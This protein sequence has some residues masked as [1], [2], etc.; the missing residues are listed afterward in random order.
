MNVAIN[1]SN[2][3]TDFMHIRTEF[4]GLTSTATPTNARGRMLKGN[5]CNMCD[6]ICGARL[7]HT[8][9]TIIGNPTGSF[10]FAVCGAGSVE[11][12][13]VR[14]LAISDDAVCS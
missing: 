7:T 5:R 10:V 1:F 6:A 2:F 12:S 11:A 3:E 4:A 9:T 14:A 8:L 13:G